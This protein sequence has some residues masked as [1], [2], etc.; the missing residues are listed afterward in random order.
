[1]SKL[2]FLPVAILVLSQTL[3]AV[4]QNKKSQSK[5]FEHSKAIYLETFLDKTKL[6][7][8]TGFFITYKN[9]AYFVTNYHIV[10]GR[11]ALTNKIKDVDQRL[12]NR[13]KLY[14]VDTAGGS[15]SLDIPVK[16]DWQSS[17][18]LSNLHIDAAIIK[19]P[20]QS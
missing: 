5:K 18:I 15:V 14:L 17:V 6:S 20:K 8:G 2:K 12:P 9:S 10:T 3:L 11:D 16:S 19:L 1:M 4:A 7:T 13:I